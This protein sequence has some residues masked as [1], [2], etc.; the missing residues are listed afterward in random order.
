MGVPPPSTTTVNADP[1]A[2]GLARD[3]ADDAKQ[4]M[5]ATAGGASDVGGKLSPSFS[6]ADE[7]DPLGAAG[8]FADGDG[9]YTL[10]EALERCGRFGRFQLGMLGFTGLSW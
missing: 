2:A 9:F 6:P 8:A 10:D 1:A 3:P 7:E 4:L 5:P